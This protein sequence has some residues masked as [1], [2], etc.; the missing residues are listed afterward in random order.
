MVR[1]SGPGRYDR[2]L[3]T[4]E[5]TRTRREALLDGATEVFARRGYAGTRVDD[6]VE[7]TGISRRTLYQHFESVDTLLEQIYERA[8]RESFK[9]VLARLG[10]AR[11]PVDRIH[12]GIA[13]F[14]ALIAE[15]PAAAR[16]V[17]EVY[18]NAGAAQATRH[19]LNTTRYATVMLDFLNGVFAAGK[20]SRP[21]DEATV[22]A[23]S[24]GLEAVAVR[25]LHRE[26]HASLPSMAPAMSHMVLHAFGH[27]G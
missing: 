19:E 5:R 4:D 23:L 27:A 14:Y 16:V 24:K 7:Q 17:F 1:P 18:R 13:A 2:S 26:E 15:H 20:I 6:I 22:Y 8:V 25:A 12:A 3:S 11:D 21:P 9:F 10:R